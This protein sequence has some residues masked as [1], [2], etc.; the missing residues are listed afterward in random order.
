MFTLRILPITISNIYK[1]FKFLVYPLYYIE[2]SVCADIHEHGIACIN[3]KDYGIQEP[4]AVGYY[5]VDLTQ[6]IIRLG[7][8]ISKIS[9]P[10]WGRIVC[11]FMW[12]PTVSSNIWNYII[13]DLPERGYNICI[14]NR[15]HTS[16]FAKK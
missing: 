1:T 4:L 10:D 14:A 13:F 9:S 3:K 2:C 5:T 11:P 7:Y 16:L 8:N 15:K 6:L 12:P